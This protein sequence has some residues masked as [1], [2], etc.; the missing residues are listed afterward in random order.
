MSIAQF[1]P[2]DVVKVVAQ[3]VT[4]LGEFARYAGVEALE[5]IPAGAP[6][7]AVRIY[8]FRGAK[9]K[10]YFDEK[11]R[12]PSEGGW[13][14]PIPDA[15]ITSHFNPNRMHPVLKRRM[16][17]NGTDFGAPTGTPIGASSYGVV[18]FVGDGGPAGNLVM[19]KHDDDI[20]T[21]YAHLSR[22]AEGLKVG[23]RVERMQVIGYCGSTGRS[24]GPHLHF[25]AK[26][27]GQY[28][29]PLSLKLDA[30]AVLPSS[31]RQAFEEFKS[32]FAAL[33]AEIPTP[34]ADAEPA[35]KAE[36]A[37][38]P[39]GDDELAAAPAPASPSLPVADVVVQPTGAR[40]AGGRTGVDLSKASI[41]MSDADLLKAQGA[42]DDGEVDE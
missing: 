41:H 28:I 5:Y 17:H 13:R 4:V 31:E 37:V 8:Y 3:E 39:A 33:F 30:L 40:P 38:E 36:A 34:A 12:S 11:G 26:R 27:K 1:K 14:R 25:I 23:Q 35:P 42:S 19:I 22:F 21:G 20:E 9:A 18:S 16:P 10:G 32:R 6:E 2:G 29:D 7:K 24:T 15:P